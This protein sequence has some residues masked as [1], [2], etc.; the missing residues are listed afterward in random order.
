M[1]TLKIGV[2]LLALLLAAMIMVPMVSAAETSST[3]T[4]MVKVDP[5]TDTLGFVAVDVITIDPAVK[6]ATPY[7]Q[8]LV[9][10]D[11]GKQNLLN[12]I[13]SASSV[14]ASDSMFTTE[15]KTSM[16]ASLT[17]LWKKYPVI[18][19]TK[20]GGS[21]YPTYGGTI[22]TIRFAPAIKGPYLTDQEN[23]VLNNTQTMMNEIYSQKQANAITPMWAT[24]P[25]HKRISYWAA[26]KESF[27]QPDTVSNNAPV[28]DSWYDT[29]IDPLKAIVHSWYHYYDPVYGTGG[30]PGRTLAYVTYAHSYYQSNDYTDAAINLGYSSHFIEDVGNPM[31]TG[32]ESDQ[33][34]NPWV[35]SNY[36]GYVGNNWYNRSKGASFEDVVQNNNNYYW[37]TDWS[38]GT[39]NLATYSHGYVDTIYTKVYNKGL[40]WDLS[41]DDTS[42]V[43]ITQNLIQATATYTNG[44]ALYA[45][46]G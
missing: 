25:T 9:L 13:D 43:A 19:D 34:S 41:M 14:V 39:M 6:N 3:S 8:I 7:Y 11:E 28:P 1:K 35:H 24:D 27:P 20:K 30:A 38:Q 37:T 10:N 29:I 5:K 17:N 16:K 36:E 12:N 42:I 44:L 26:Y 32:R 4:Q 23:L 40:N 22:T 15:A 2:M 31:H 33:I 45:R 21:G 46:T 18:Y